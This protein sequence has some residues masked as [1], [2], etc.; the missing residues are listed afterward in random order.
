MIDSSA[1]F[2][3]IGKQRGSFRR[4]FEGAQEQL[5]SKFGMEMVELPA[6]EKTTMK[7][8]RGLSIPWFLVAK[9][10]IYSCTE[11]ERWFEDYVFLHPHNNTTNEIPHTRDNATVYHW[12]RG[13]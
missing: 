11:V 13:K 8:K 2:I 7:E 5:R 6:R 10:T 4:V 3:V 9:L 12:E 1:D